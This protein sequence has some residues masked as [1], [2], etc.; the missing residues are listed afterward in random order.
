MKYY[1]GL[2]SDSGDDVEIIQH[3]NR[4]YDSGPDYKNAIIKI[5]GKTFTGDIE[6]H[7]DFKNWAE[8]SHSK[9]RRYNSVI[10][11]VVLWDDN[12]RQPPKLRIQRYLPTVILSNH[13]TASIHDIWQDIISEP[14]ERFRIPCYENNSSAADNTVITLL[15]KLSMERL[16]LKTKRISTRLAEL[17]GNPVNKEIPKARSVWEQVLYEFIFE[18]LGFS[19]NKEQMMKLASS[20][21]LKLLGKYAEKDI[22][23]IQSILYGTAGFFFDVRVK[24]DYID[25]LK[26][27]WRKTEH[28]LKNPKLQRSEWTFYGQRPQNYPTLRIAYGSQTAYNLLYEN[29]FKQLI[30]LFNTSVKPK[31]L[32]ADIFEMFAPVNDNYW[33]SHYDLGKSSKNINK[34]GG[35]QRITDII[36]N[37]LIPFVYF[38]GNTFGKPEIIQNVLN[39]YREVKINPDNNI[40]RIMNAQLFKNR[41]VKINTPA[42]EQAVIQLHNFYCT[43]EKCENCLIGKEAFKNKGYDYKIIYY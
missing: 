18:A 10:L 4:N 41:G 32:F 12:D 37:V 35:R 31:K 42:Y 38:Y 15:D 19:K 21:N 22:L 6:I 23:K 29:F 9:D 14:S 25:K 24:D 30:D 36:I 5:A 39:L 27:F 26:E 3:G 1:S 8:H 34:L 17:G 7:R 16:T 43:R 33:Q 40:I 20:A 28:R 11:H 13:L 2:V